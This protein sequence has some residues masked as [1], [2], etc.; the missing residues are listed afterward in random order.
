MNIKIKLLLLITLFVC[1]SGIG[2]NQQETFHY[3]VEIGTDNDNFI[4][5]TATDRNYTYG[6]NAG[7]RWRLQSGAFL[8]SI[9]PK[10][11]ARFAKV[12]FNLKAFTPNYREETAPETQDINRPFAGWTYATLQSTYAFENSFVRLGIEAG[13]LGPASQ[14][15]QFQNWFHQNISN[16]ASVDWT[17][18]IPNQ[19]GVNMIGSYARDLYHTSWFDTYAEVE[20]SVGNIFTYLWPQ[21][22]FRVG[23][24]NKI[25]KSVATQ[26]GILGTR[27]TN[28]LFLEY[29]LGMRF[30][31][32]NGTIQGNLFNSN[33]A[34]NQNEINNTIFT[35]NIGLNF[36]FDR[37]TILGKYHY[38]TG[39]RER[40]QVHRFGTLSLLYR[41]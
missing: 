7:L 37:F 16:D 1:F 36:S 33:D 41:F 39:E 27:A 32:Y 20:A 9:F 31:G 21:V 19:L 30:S 29:G 15:G 8:A 38:G 23:Q 4:I 22:N 17:G 26:N 6:V 11:T 28:E 10:A 35:M 18:E 3:E 12:G 13:V 14:A 24:F 2:Q 40:T 5:Y 34:F 25:T